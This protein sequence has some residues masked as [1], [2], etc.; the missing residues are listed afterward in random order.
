MIAMQQSAHG[1]GQPS[2]SNGQFA[3]IDH[4]L[5]VL[6]T[7]EDVPPG[8]LLG[9]SRLTL[10]AG[11]SDDVFLTG[12]GVVPGHVSL[13]FLEGRVTLLS[14]TQE[15]RIGDQAVTVFPCEWRPLQPLSLSADTH[16]AYGEVGADWP[17]APVW[18]LPEEVSGDDADARPATVNPVPAALTPASK[19]P[20]STRE[21]MN[22]SARM[23]AVAIGLA[24]LV[25]TGL[26]S[27]DLIWGSREVVN[28]G[29]QAI[30]R[31]QDALNKLLASDPRNFGA[32]KLTVRQDG[33]L[34]LT[35]FLES[36]AIYRKLSDQ[37]RQQLVNSGGNVR[38][39]VMTVERLNALV[40]DQL[41]RF[42]LGSRIDVTADHV[43]VTVYGVQVEPAV[44]ER[45]NKDFAQLSTRIAPRKLL[46][47][48]QLQ[49][50]EALTQEISLALAKVSATR[51]LQ[52]KLDEEGGRITGLVA[53]AV[54][55]ESRAALGE[56]QKIY[57]E[58]VP[59]TI[60]LKVDPK[61]NFTVVSVSLGGNE[62]IATM[63]QRGKTQAFRVGEPVFGNGELRDIKDDGVVL[64]MGR[65]EMFIPLIR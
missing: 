16:L 8:F 49:S 26:V 58:R 10:G 56:L 59:L 20:R 25:V 14:A 46:V 24:T 38:L 36:E 39:D 50:A 42:P 12:V 11:E 5:V 61:L 32:V 53:A 28:P 6:G 31:S 23:G 54:E 44:Q 7:G 17:A 9:A 43:G 15:I 48:F 40:R 18:V 27:A 57:A 47:D 34:S 29:G 35:G 52:F 64:A 65:R 62:S 21:R 4:M 3:P 60:D 63:M 37:V 51:D 30:D 2:T 1:A 55:A 22:F 19:A 33:A 41:A 45:L 13:I